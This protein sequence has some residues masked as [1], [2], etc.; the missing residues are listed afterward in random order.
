MF[1][2]LLHGVRRV[3]AGHRIER[4]AGEGPGAGASSKI[5][6]AKKAF[7]SN[8]GGESFETVIDQTVFDGGPDRP[9]NQFYSA[10]KDW[11]RLEIVS[12]P[13]DADLVLEISWVLTDTGLRLPVLG[14]LRLVIIDPRTHVTLWNLTE[15]VR[16]AILLG[17]RDK[18][19]DQ[20]MTTI[21]NRMKLLAVPAATP[22]N[23]G[24]K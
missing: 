6:S 8:G 19:F 23:V 21:L 15:Y 3:G 9:Y 20:A 16:G 7:I 18:N 13:S 17:N 11:G 14:Q 12:A 4:A 2:R 10:F 5:A 24:Q 22:A 1:T